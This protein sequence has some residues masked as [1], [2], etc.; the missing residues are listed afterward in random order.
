MPGSSQN[1]QLKDA[2][3]VIDDVIKSNPPKGMYYA[4]KA[5]YHLELGEYEEDLKT[6][7]VA[8]RIMPDSVPLYDMRGTMLEGFQLYDEA[9]QDFTMTFQ[10]AKGSNVK[11]H[12]LANRGGTKITIRDFEGAYSDLMM[13][14]QLNSLNIDAL[15]NL[16]AV[17]DEVNR[18]DETLKYLE[19]AIA[20]DPNY[21]GAYINLGFK[22]QMCL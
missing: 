8:I 12:L 7:V 3:T 5:A 16:A 2:I 14:V 15:T 21:F 13:A 9:I 10:K 11:S 4:D 1:Q 20:I 6:L 18:P 19:Q 17:C 22:Y